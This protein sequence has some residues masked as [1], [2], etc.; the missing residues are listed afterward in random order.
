MK[1]LLDLIRALVVAA[2]CSVERASA[3]KRRQLLHRKVGGGRS[4]KEKRKAGLGRRKKALEGKNKNRLVQQGLA[5]GAASNSEEALGNRLGRK[6]PRV[7]RVGLLN[8]MGLAV[9]ARSAKGKQL[10]DFLKERQLDFMRLSEVNVSWSEA[11]TRH[12]LDERALRWL[13]Q[14]SQKVV[15]SIRSDSN[16]AQLLGGVAMLSTNGAASKVM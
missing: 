13:K 2:A 15:W 10:L 6:E 4:H 1:L 8:P 3:D 5:E 11:A 12:K 9:R 14:M 7:R 16:K